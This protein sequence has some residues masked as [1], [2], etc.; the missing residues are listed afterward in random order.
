MKN[1][2]SN[3]KY[4][5]LVLTVILILVVIALGRESY[6]YFKISQEIR[7]LEKQIEEFKKDNEE[8]SKMKDY[9]QSKEFLQ[10][11]ARGKLNLVKKGEKLIIVSNEGDLQEEIKLE[12]KENKTSNIKLWLEYFFGNN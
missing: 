2:F 8:L 11:E 12:E 9:F 4:F 1:N 6:R 3:S 5:S 10:D 7:D